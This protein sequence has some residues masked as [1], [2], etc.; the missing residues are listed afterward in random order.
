MTG[1]EGPNGH[2]ILA[3]VGGDA[4]GIA[5][6]IR[7]ADLP[8]VAGPEPATRGPRDATAQA[9]IA[10]VRRA[11][12]ALRAERARAPVRRRREDIRDFLSISMA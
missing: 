8:G 9:D 6:G 5:G 7:D 11:G 10:D 4:L 1:V 3:G 2:Q 12:T